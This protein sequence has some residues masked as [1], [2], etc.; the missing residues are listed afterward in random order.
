MQLLTPLALHN[1][2]DVRSVVKH[3]GL[4]Y[5]NELRV[6]DD[7]ISIVRSFHARPPMTGIVPNEL[8]EQVPWLRRN[9]SD[10]AWERQCFAMFHRLNMSD[11]RA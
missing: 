2:I 10:S 8:A 9:E 5:L 11:I 1:I 7:F 3:A 4:K 6:H